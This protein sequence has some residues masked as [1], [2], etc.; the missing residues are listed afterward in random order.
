MKKLC[1]I[2]AGDHA[3]KNLYPSALLCGAEIVGVSTRNMQSAKSAISRFGLESAAAFDNYHEMLR[4]SD[5]DGVVISVGVDNQFDIVC[6]VIKAGKP[7]FVEKPL[8]LTSAQAEHVAKLADEFGVIGMVAFM[9][10]FA[11]AHMR[12]EEAIFGGAIGT[13]L[14]FHAMMAVDCTKFTDNEEDMLKCAMIHYLDLTRHIFGDA[15]AVRGFSNSVGAN[16]N[17]CF[18]VK[19]ENDVCG[20]LYFSGSTPWTRHEESFIVTGDNGIARVDNFTKF[21]LHKSRDIKDVRWQTLSEC[22]EVFTPASSTSGG[23]FRDLYMNGFV[24]EFEHFLHCT[25][26]SE[27]PITNLWD[28]VKTMKLCEDVL[29]ACNAE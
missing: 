3:C 27:T 24:G 22:D 8:G 26:T 9:K 14:S 17:L 5:C 12:L 23:G 4:T 25:E 10:R 21:T 29:V 2:G 7:F 20:N 28:N 19:F 11:P 1:F 18:S 6:D 13:P 16:T 15:T